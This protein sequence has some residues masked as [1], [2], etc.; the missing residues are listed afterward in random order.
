[1]EDFVSNHHRDE[2][3]V[4]PGDVNLTMTTRHAGQFNSSLSWFFGTSLGTTLPTGSMIDNP[5]VLGGPWRL[6]HQHIFFGRGMPAPMVG[7]TGSLRSGWGFF[8]AGVNAT[9]PFLKTPSK[10]YIPT[11]GQPEY[12]TQHDWDVYELGHYLAPKSITTNLGLG[13]NFGTDDWSFTAT[14]QVQH[15]EQAKWQGFPQANTGKTEILVGAR[16]SFAINPSMM[17]ELNIRVPVYLH[18]PTASEQIEMP[19]LLGFGFYYT[20]DL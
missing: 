18:T 10:R 9:I 15:E 17:V 4:G 13:S 2:T 12:D 5:E 16:S 8:E 1:M 14:T 19:F 7:I 3:L 11:P 6:S 20:L